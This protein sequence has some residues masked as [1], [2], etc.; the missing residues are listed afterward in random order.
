M[1]RW[2]KGIDVELCK[3]PGNFNL[4]R[5]RTIVLLEADYNTNCKKIGRDAL[6]SAEQQA[7]AEK[8]QQ[9]QFEDRSSLRGRIDD[10]H[11]CDEHQE[12]VEQEFDW[13][14]RQAPILRIR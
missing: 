10:R 4:E 1:V 12:H 8:A 13:D 7:A 5:L 14:N 11:T 6:H 9:E 2:K 3:E